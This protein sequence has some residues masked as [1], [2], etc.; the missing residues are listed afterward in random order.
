[1]AFWLCDDRDGRSQS[2]GPKLELVMLILSKELEMPCPFLVDLSLNALASNLLRAES[3]C[4]MSVENWDGRK[5]I[6]AWSV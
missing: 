3:V 4:S 6:Y 2:R 1:M 5:R